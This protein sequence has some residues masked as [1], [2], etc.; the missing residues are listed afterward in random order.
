[1]K[2]IEK[3]QLFTEVTDEEAATISGGGFFGAPWDTVVGK[4]LFYANPWAGA[5]Y[6]VAGVTYDLY[7]LNNGTYSEREKVKRDVRQRNGGRLVAS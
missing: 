3:S 5:L 2:D 1:M 6:S 7:R 4:A